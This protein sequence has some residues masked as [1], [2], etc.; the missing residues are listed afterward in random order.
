MKPILQYTLPAIASIM[1]GIVIGAQLWN[2]QTPET[3]PP[4]TPGAGTEVRAKSLAGNALRL[5]REGE[6]AKSI[7]MLDAAFRMAA[8]NPTLLADLTRRVIAFTEEDDVIHNRDD[9]VLLE[10]LD[11]A[12][13]A[14]LGSAT[15][16]SDFGILWR[17]REAVLKTRS[18]LISRDIDEI[19]TLMAA[20][21]VKLETEE[22]PEDK[23][24]VLTNHLALNLSDTSEP[25]QMAVS[26]LLAATDEDN[27]SQKAL[28][29]AIQD[30]LLTALESADLVASELES[31]ITAA[32]ANA[33]E[34]AASQLAPENQDGAF[35]AIMIDIG[36]LIE[37]LDGAFPASWISHADAE[38]GKTYFDVSDRLDSMFARTMK[39]QR[40][41]YNLWAMTQIHAADDA[42]GWAERL[43]S[44]DL[45]L[46]HPA[47]STLYSQ[48]FEKRLAQQQGGNQHRAVRILLNQPKPEL[49]RF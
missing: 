37:A 9:L 15:N 24:I 36:D 42:S 28:I 14:R 25:L 43:G 21:S 18:D 33:R 46:L 27:P 8:D 22:D 19:A 17:A 34:S 1:L 39:L 44:I 7:S 40:L 20:L 10:L 49:S 2:V 23:I 31:R 35:Q 30:A 4:P 45:N 32:V 6:V 13:R 47:V 41:G 29:T 26:R 48:T 16:E 38:T 5:A 12:L 3:A 11:Q